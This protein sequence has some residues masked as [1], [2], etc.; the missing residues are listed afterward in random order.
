M[1]RS[2]AYHFRSLESLF[3]LGGGTLRTA[4]MNYQTQMVQTTD[5]D[6]ETI[7]NVERRMQTIKSYD[8]EKRRLL[9]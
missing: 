6:N 1:K 4:K 5:N 2:D 7:P 9:R 3:S 8:F